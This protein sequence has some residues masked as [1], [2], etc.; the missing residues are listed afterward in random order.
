MLNKTYKKNK[1]KGFTLIETLVITI[2]LI[3]V[4]ISLASIIQGLTTSSTRIKRLQ[5][6][7]AQTQEAIHYLTKELRMS[8]FEEH[9]ST[10][11]TFNWRKEDTTG[12]YYSE[13]STTLD[14]GTLE[15][16][17]S[18]GWTEINDFKFVASGTI[19]TESKVGNEG[20]PNN[21]II[22]FYNVKVD[23]GV[24]QDEEIIIPV[25]IAVSLRSYN[26]TE[27]D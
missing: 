23:T 13:E 16:F 26:L 17:Y 24:A 9:D 7:S 15:S 14:E 6:V 1:Q 25:Q 18:Q 27:E 12:N 19:D 2:I 5:T 20:S 8:E 22:I 11:I 4:I 3:L 10:S 21:R